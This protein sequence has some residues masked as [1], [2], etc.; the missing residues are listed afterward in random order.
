MK[1][2]YADEN[3]DVFVFDQPGQYAGGGRADT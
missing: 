3:L 1:D 2:E